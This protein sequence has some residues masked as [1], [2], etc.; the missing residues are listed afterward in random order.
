[1]SDFE[2]ILDHL[3]PSAAPF[4]SFLHRVEATKLLLTNKKIAEKVTS[5]ARRWG[6][7]PS[8]YVEHADGR[9][10]LTTSEGSV[11]FR[12]LRPWQRLGFSKT[13]ISR[14]K[15]FPELTHDI[16]VVGNHCGSKHLLSASSADVRAIYKEAKPYMEIRKVKLEKEELEETEAKAA[17]EKAAFLAKKTIK[18]NNLGPPT[19]PWAKKPLS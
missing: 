16:I 14:R 18:I 15:L 8:P 12:P 19:Y 11:T 10:T 17:A 9:F 2:I 6:F 3:G 7:R 1:M 13:S 4:M 5:H